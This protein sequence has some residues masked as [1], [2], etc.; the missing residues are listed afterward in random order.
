MLFHINDAYTGN[1]RCNE[2]H[3][4][5]AAISIFTAPN[6]LAIKIWNNHGY[7]FWVPFCFV[8]CLY[9][10]FYIF[11]IGDVQ[12]KLFI[13]LVS[14]ISALFV[15]L[16]G[17]KL[18]NKKVGYFSFLLLLTDPIFFLFMEETFKNMFDA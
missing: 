1:H 14:C 4:A 13:I 6:P 17:K 16:I 15:F 9:I 18:F 12:V 11:G 3:Y 7:L 2:A 5:Y 10:F 8:W